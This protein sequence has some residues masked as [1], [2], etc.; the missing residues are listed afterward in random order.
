MCI[1]IY[2]YILYI[3]CYHLMKFQLKC[4]EPRPSLCSH[5]RRSAPRFV[6]EDSTHQMME[7]KVG[8]ASGRCWWSL[9]LKRTRYI[10]TYIYISVYV[11]RHTHIYIYYD[12]HAFSI[13]IYITSYIMY[14]HWIFWYVWYPKWLR[15]QNECGR[16]IQVDVCEG[17]KHLKLITAPRQRYMIV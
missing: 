12:I 16:C 1:Y 15:L 7:L 6:V 9:V 14:I 8:F 2:L 11:C 10:Y 3:I 13:Y 5:H 4:W 17:C